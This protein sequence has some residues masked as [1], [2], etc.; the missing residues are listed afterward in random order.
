MFLLFGVCGPSFAQLFY[1]K[2][3]DLESF[4]FFR[5]GCGAHTQ[6]AQGHDLRTAVD[7]APLEPVGVG[8]ADDFETLHVG[9]GRNV[10]GSGAAIGIS[11]FLLPR[12][13][14]VIF[15]KHSVQAGQQ[16]SI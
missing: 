3:G 7:S 14:S 1:V 15:T 4:C 9:A 6:K 10:P 11:G 8:A 16:L 2:A 12:H 5:S 13:L